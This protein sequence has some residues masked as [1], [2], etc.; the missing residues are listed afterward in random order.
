MSNRFEVVDPRGRKVTC[1]DECWQGHILAARPWMAG[2]ENEVQSAIQHPTFGIYHDAT[3]ESRHLYY[4]L[5]TNRRQYIKVVVDF[6]EAE[7]GTVITAFPTD[8]PKSGEKL[9]WPESSI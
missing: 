6:G 5:R 7:T 3:H 2:W 9:L 1:T 8:S 4:R